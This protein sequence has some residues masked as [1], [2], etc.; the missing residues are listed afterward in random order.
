M[1]VYEQ[2]RRDRLTDCIGDYLSDENYDSF[3]IYNEILGEVESMIQYH[4]QN[5]EKCEQLKSLLKG[6]HSVITYDDPVNEIA[7][8]LDTL[9]NFVL[10]DK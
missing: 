1:E 8:E 7:Q 5:L 6:G 2:S 10:G 9:A 3:K 4:K